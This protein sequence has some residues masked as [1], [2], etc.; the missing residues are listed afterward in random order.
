MHFPPWGTPLTQMAVVTQ[1]YG[2]PFIDVAQPRPKG[3]ELQGFF[4]SVLLTLVMILVCCEG[5]RGLST[6]PFIAVEE[7]ADASR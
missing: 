4:D 3:N 2:D 6:V 7:N 1:T 5:N